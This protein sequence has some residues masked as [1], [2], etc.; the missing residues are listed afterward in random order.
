M[1]RILVLTNMYPPH[2][3]GGYEL[4]CED[5]VARWRDHGHDVT[6]LT[7]TVR[8]PGVEGPEPDPSVLR[9]LE[10]YWR[11]HE[12]LR[13][14]LLRRLR[15]ERR[16][17][18][19]LA[20]ALERFRP[21]VVSVWNMGAMSLGLLGALEARGVPVVY[22]VCNE[23]PAA[24]GG[25]D[26]WASAFHGRPLL[27]S[28]ASRLS[29]VPAPPRRLGAS[30]AFCFVSEATRQLAEAALG[31]V[32]LGTVVYSGISTE[33]FPVPSSPP[34]PRPWR[35][36]LLF[37]GRV[38]PDKGVETALRALPLLPPAAGLVVAGRGRPGELARLSALAAGLG[39][40]DRVRF[41]ALGRAQ[42]A[43]RYREADALA[44]CSL[45]EEPFGLVPV[46]AM[47]C[48]TP[49]VA[50]RRG[51]SAEVLVDG[52][53]CLEVPPGDPAALAA[54]LRR[55][56]A[57]PGLRSRLVAGGLETARELTVDR[58]AATLE[59]WHV[60]AAERF[61]RGRPPDRPPLVGPRPSAPTT[62]PEAPGARPEALPKELEALPVARPEAPDGASA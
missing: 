62:L 11:D 26:A 25:M 1:T 21:E 40:A 34:P 12:L 28:V 53:N 32:P 58:L 18:R 4:S 52:V 20:E 2:H 10:L 19:A 56:A 55:L 29:G 23:W 16:N 42:L 35:W 45:W 59:T 7:S 8:V 24:A 17:Q 44:F 22:V 39:V 57:D 30:G 61:A 49:V 54:A 36:R 27:A 48:A 31:P 41:E 37:A 47:A 13:P 50:T 51:G 14:P 5:V 46:E 43:R 3:Y 6:V 9:R 33:H 38:D 60:A 15:I